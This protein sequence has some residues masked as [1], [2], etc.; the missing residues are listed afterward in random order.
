MTKKV[1]V[2]KVSKIGRNE[3]KIRRNVTNVGTCKEKVCEKQATPTRDP[4]VTHLGPTQER[5]RDTTHF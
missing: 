4:L 5:L 2:S 3:I 1:L